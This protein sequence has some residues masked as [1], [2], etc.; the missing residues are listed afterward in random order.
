MA[1]DAAAIPEQ[2]PRRPPVSLV[3]F[4]KGSLLRVL[5]FNYIAIIIVY[6]DVVIIQR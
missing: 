6:P 3:F 1:V 5:Y 4:A 2:I